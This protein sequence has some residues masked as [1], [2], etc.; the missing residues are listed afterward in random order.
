MSKSSTVKSFTAGS[1]PAGSIPAGSRTV[2]GSKAAHRLTPLA[3]AAALVSLAACSGDVQPLIEAVEVAELG[4][5]TLS[6]V[7]PEGSITDPVLTVNPRDQ[8]AFTL[9]GTGAGGVEVPV[10][11][12]E[13][14]W[15]ISDHA[16]GNI[17]EDGLFTA[18]ADGAASITVGIG[19]VVAREFDVVVNESAVSTIEPIVGPMTLD[20]CVQSS[21]SAVAGFVDGSRRLLQTSQVEWSSSDTGVRVSESDDGRASVSATDPG[22]ITLTATAGSAGQ[23]LAISV[24][25]D[26][27]QSIDIG[28]ASLVADRGETTQLSATGTYMIDARSTAR[29]IT[30]TVDWD[31]T[32]GDDFISV[33]NEAADRG[34]LTALSSGSGE[35]RAR[36]G[37]VERREN[38]VVR[39]SDSSDDSLSFDAPDNNILVI[40]LNGGPVQ[41]RVSTGSEYDATDEITNNVAVL[42]QVLDSNQQFISL[43]TQDPIRGLVTPRDVGATTIRVSFDGEQA[44]LTINVVGSL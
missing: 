39:S 14:R 42:W 8:I 32:T 15:R 16:V 29:S 2:A 11:S 33:S 34:L 9:Q 30:D 41:V 35:V 24:S 25:A 3:T 43:G 7:A 20:P 26:S 5:E 31:V 36:C 19:N 38:F 1:V 13:R 12:D 6:I 22:A 27:L 18:S 44:D 10:K 37:S 17:S 4:I 23:D 28:P 21:Y 40:P